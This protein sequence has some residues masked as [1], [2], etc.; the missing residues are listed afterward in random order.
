MTWYEEALGTAEEQAKVFAAWAVLGLLAWLWGWPW[1]AAGCA[2]VVG[3]GMLSVLVELADQDDDGL[4]IPDYVADE[5]AYR[6]YVDPDSD[7]TEAEFERRQA[8][9][10]DPSRSRTMEIVAEA[11][12]IGADRQLAIAETFGSVET[13]AAHEPDEVA[14]RVDDVGEVLAERAVREA[15]DAA[16][17]RQL[18]TA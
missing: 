1:V 10:L 13:L 16:A 4:D 8:A 3:V 18:A 11:D 15:R 6:E 2:A 5:T 17:T 7:M 12:G 9:A 14:E